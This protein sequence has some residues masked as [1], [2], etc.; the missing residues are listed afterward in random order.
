MLSNLLLERVFV[1]RDELIHLLTI[2]DEEEGRDATDFPFKSNLSGLVDV[3]FQEH[4]FWV[5]SR[6]ASESRADVTAGPTPRCGEV[7]N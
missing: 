5:L 4:D 6:Q 7:E 1:H 2:S 3:H